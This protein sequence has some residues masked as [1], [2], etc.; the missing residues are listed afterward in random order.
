[1]MQKRNEVVSAVK[2]KVNPTSAQWSLDR[3]LNGQNKVSSM[4]E[5]Q[6]VAARKE[7]EAW[8]VHFRCY[9]S[10][11][12]RWTRWWCEHFDAESDGQNGT[13]SSKKSP[14]WRAAARFGRLI[15]Y[16]FI[17][18]RFKRRS[19]CGCCLVWWNQLFA[20][21][22]LFIFWL[23]PSFFFFCFVLLVSN[24]IQ[25]GRVNEQK[26]KVATKSTRKGEIKSNREFKQE[27]KTKRISD[28]ARDN[29]R[30]ANEL[31]NHDEEI[32]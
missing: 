22:Y 2:Q 14:C 20:L 26:E 24:S 28:D 31:E 32:K 30:S 10:I 7:C 11:C 21:L 27:R 1:M 8:I 15:G 9:V 29:E 16:K 12:D 17:V 19:V 3:K 25:F 18:I 6:R 4:V 23:G 13:T 5:R